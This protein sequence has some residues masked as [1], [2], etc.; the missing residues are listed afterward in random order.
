MNENEKTVTTSQDT[1]Q[2]ENAPNTAPKTAEPFVPVKYNKEV[3][4]LSLEKAGELAQKGMKFEALSDELTLLKELAS[5]SGKTVMQFLNSIKAQNTDAMIN[6]LM[7]K[8]G[9][10]T[11]LANEVSKLFSKN[12]EADDGFSELQKHFPEI[13]SRDALPESVLENASLC[14]RPLL[15][16]FLRY[17]LQQ[18]KAVRENFLS[19]QRARLS[20]TGSLLNKSG[21]ENPEAAEFLKGLWRK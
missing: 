15:D 18:E 19:Q 8:C 9:D 2:N 20:S 5:Q 6:S 10:D 12:E 17:R 21:D 13:K 3:I 16:E 1:D 11:A 14:A 4:N 7:K